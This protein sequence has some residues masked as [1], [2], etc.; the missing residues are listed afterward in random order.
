M[1]EEEMKKR[2]LKSLEA[3]D[4]GE[5]NLPLDM[6]RTENSINTFSHNSTTESGDL[7]L[8]SILHSPIH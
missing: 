7:S 8:Q 4:Q 5:L 1:T 2:L 3:D 6:N